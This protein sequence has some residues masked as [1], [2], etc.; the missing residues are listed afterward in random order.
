MRRKVFVTQHPGARAIDLTAAQVF[1]ELVYCSWA[2]EVEC[3]SVDLL[4]ENM[5]GRMGSMAPG[6]FVLPLGAPITMMLAGLIAHSVTGGLF[7]VLY[8]DRQQ[9]V[10]QVLPVNS[11]I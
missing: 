4:L 7:Y 1:G 10:Y 3:A 8:W 5:K 2:P 9:Q 11:T 6:D